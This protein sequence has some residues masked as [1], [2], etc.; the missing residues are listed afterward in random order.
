MP[1]QM[2]LKE[3]KSE[4]ANDSGWFRTLLD[5]LTSAIEKKPLSIFYNISQW[6]IK[7]LFPTIVNN[8]PL[9]YYLEIFYLSLLERSIQTFNRGAFLSILI[10]LRDLVDEIGPEPENDKEKTKLK[11][12]RKEKE[13]TKGIEFSLFLINLKS[14][15]LS[16]RVDDYFLSAFISDFLAKLSLPFSGADKYNEQ[17]AQTSL[18]ILMSIVQDKSLPTTT[19]CEALNRLKQISDTY[20]GWRF[21]T[22]RSLKETFIITRDLLKNSNIESFWEKCWEFQ[23]S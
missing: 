20:D 14:T 22:S 18:K 6:K 9:A 7:P 3:L 1:R 11:N 10:H 15:L 19:R 5:L 21:K 16:Q 4:Q 13:K 8:F 2:T 12:G 23:T 17:I